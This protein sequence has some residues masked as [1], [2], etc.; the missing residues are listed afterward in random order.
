MFVQSAAGTHIGGAEHSIEGDHTFTNPKS[1]TV[2][3]VLLVQLLH[4]L[5]VYAIAALL[6]MGRKNK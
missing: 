6:A 5:R 4:C 1:V 3:S 2:A